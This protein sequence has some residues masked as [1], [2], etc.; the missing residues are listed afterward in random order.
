MLS[1]MKKM[2]IM[3]H[4]MLMNVNIPPNCLLFFNSFLGLVTY[5][6]IDTEPLARKVLSLNDDK[7]FS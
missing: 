3:I 4:L 1:A 5:D 7:P 2:Q 6:L